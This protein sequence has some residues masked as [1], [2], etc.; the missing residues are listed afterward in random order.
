MNA[1]YVEAVACAAYLHGLAGDLA[2]ANIGQY[3]M[4]SADIA[5][6]ISSAINE[7]TGF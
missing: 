2:A 4:T 1:T 5:D 6:A 3:G 7:V